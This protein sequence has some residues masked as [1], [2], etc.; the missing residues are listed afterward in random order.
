MAAGAPSPQI[1]VRRPGR[2]Q[3]LAGG[4]GRALHLGLPALLLLLFSLLVFHSYQLLGRPLTHQLSA[5]RAAAPA[6]QQPPV[7]APVFTPT[8]HRWAPLIDAAASENE[9]PA[10]LISTVIQIESCGD[11]KAVSPAGALGLMQV[12]PYHFSADQDPLEP[13]VNLFVGTEYLR[14]AIELAHG[15]IAAAL[16]GYNGGHGQIDRPSISWPEETQRYVLW[17]SGIYAD[18]DRDAANSPTLDRWLAAGGRN[19]CRQ[20][21]LHL[22]AP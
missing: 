2:A 16:A 1:R 9:L 14:R 10:A 12:M 22:S 7:L 19:L 11:P 3:G 20:A 17:G 13:G 15:D 6:V 5:Q 18:A 8:V 21:G 4:P